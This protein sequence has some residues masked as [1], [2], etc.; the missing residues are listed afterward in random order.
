L[1]ILKKIHAPRYIR[2][3]GIVS[4]LLASPITSDSQHLTTSIVEIKPGGK[5]RVHSHT[6]EQIYYILEG[7]GHMTV[8]DE[9][10]RVEPGDCI[11]IPS[12]A[13]HGLMNDGDVVLRYFS[14]AAPAFGR[15]QLKKL[16]PLRS[17]VEDKKGGQDDV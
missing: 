12:G 11:F 1:I 15:E 2:E 8:S 7:R 16:W 14:A 6:P 13:S 10:A 4:Y 3:E 9:T 5:Q 17:E